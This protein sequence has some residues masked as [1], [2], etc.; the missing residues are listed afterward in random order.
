M[1]EKS[2]IEDT[3]DNPYCQKE[4]AD[5]TIRIYLESPVLKLSFVEQA[6]VACY[7]QGI[8]SALGIP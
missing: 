3:P 8:K 2:S 4:L 6:D 1:E 5:I 7:N